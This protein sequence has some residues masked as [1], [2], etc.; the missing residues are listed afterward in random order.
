[1]SEPSVIGTSTLPARRLT[2]L[3]EHFP[4]AVDQSVRDSL[5]IDLESSFADGLPDLFDFFQIESRL[6][7]AHGMQGGSNHGCRL[8]CGGGSRGGVC[9]RR[10]SSSHAGT[11]RALHGS[12]NL[13]GTVDLHGWQLSSYMQR[14]LAFTANLAIT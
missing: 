8:P 7:T 6:G 5:G 14:L 9:S 4:N 1:M 3:I 11:G 13:R 10:A 2:I 12:G